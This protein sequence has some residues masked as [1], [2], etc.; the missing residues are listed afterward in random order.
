MLMRYAQKHALGEVRQQGF[1]I[2]ELMIA[3]VV[4]STIMVLAST[5]VVR[6]TNT[7]Q[8]GLTQTAT[9]N[10]TR[11]II[12]D[13]SEM[14]QT[15]G[16][17][18]FDGSLEQQGTSKGICVQGVRYS[19]ILNSRLSST[20]SG[21]GSVT[22]RALVKDSGH[23]SGCGGDALNI[24]TSNAGAELLAQNMRLVSL[25]VNPVSGSGST[26]YMVSVKVAYGEDDQFENLNPDTIRC[27]GG[28]GSQYCAVSSLSTT[29]KRRL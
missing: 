24:S 29:V 17:S 23:S 6:F 22:G 2:V 28:A 26:L 16:P 5:T 19:Y 18:E 10:T 21:F 14:L 4:F 9:Q 1:T 3:T 7:F 11:A 13:I 25:N 20:G 8:R 27:N 12:D 15:T